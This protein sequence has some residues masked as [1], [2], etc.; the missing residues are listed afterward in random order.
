MQRSWGRMR[1][2]PRSLTAKTT[3][4]DALA[5]YPAAARVLLAR[6]MHCIGCDVAR[7][8]TIADACAV[9]GV[10]PEELIA[11]IRRSATTQ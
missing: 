6:R 11:D 2:Y 7:F 9:Y 3:I 4:A 10:E 1:T 5:A 8:E